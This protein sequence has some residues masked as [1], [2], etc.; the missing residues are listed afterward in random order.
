MQSIFFRM[1]HPFGDNLEDGF[2]VPREIAEL[3][4]FREPEEL[5]ILIHQLNLLDEKIEK[6]LVE[7]HTEREFHAKQGY[8]IRFLKNSVT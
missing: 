5:H 8:D 3:T 4:V 6:S 1:H 7:A 2:V